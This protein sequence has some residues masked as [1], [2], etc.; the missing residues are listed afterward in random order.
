MHSTKKVLSDESPIA[1][2]SAIF[3]EVKNWT[4]LLKKDHENQTVNFI[5][6]AKLFELKNGEKKLIGEVCENG[7]LYNDKEN[8]GLCQR[9]FF[10]IEVKGGESSDTL[11]WTPPSYHNVII[12]SKQNIFLTDSTHFFNAG[13]TRRS[14]LQ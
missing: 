6:S 7:K 5:R 9:R 3:F 1:P 11:V 12:H 2:R 10:K 8:V 13:H 4:S 14:L